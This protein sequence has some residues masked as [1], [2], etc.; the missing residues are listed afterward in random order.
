MWYKLGQEILYSICVWYKLRTGNSL[1]YMRCIWRLG[2]EILKIVYRNR[3]P[4]WYKLGQE[5]VYSMWKSNCMW[6]KLG[7]E[8][9]L[10]YIVCGIS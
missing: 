4:M 5:I 8:I 6:Y 2:Q 9:V 1:Q 10:Q 3:K 7:Q